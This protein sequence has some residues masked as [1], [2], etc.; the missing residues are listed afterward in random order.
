M[1]VYMAKILKASSREFTE[2]K[3]KIDGYRLFTDTSRA[4]AQIQP[5]NLNFDLRKLNPGQCSAPLHYHHYAEEMFLVMQG[6]MM[7]R[8]TEG[9]FPIANGDII[10]C[11]KG[12]TGAHQFY[13]DSSEPCIYLDIRSFLEYDLCEYPESNKLFIAPQYRIFT[14]ASIANYFDGEENPMEKWRG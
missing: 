7:L 11:E 8:T 13:N 3:N 12:E 4:Y 9:K 2:D 6:S 10:F 1:E 5:E 14:K